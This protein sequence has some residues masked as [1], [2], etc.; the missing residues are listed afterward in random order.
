MCTKISTLWDKNRPFHKL[1][2]REIRWYIVIEDKVLLIKHFSYTVFCKLVNVL[3]LVVNC[4]EGYCLALIKLCGCIMDDAD[5]SGRPLVLTFSLN[6][7]EAYRH[8]YVLR[9]GCFF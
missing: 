4:L 8:Q 6:I 2:K 5:S 7:C 3:S 1:E 9:L